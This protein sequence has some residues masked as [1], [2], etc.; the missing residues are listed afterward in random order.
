MIRQPIP[1]SHVHKFENGSRGSSTGWNQQQNFDPL[2]TNTYAHI[3]QE[4]GSVTPITPDFPQHPSSY[5]AG[6][7]GFATGR[8][9]HSPHL[10]P[11]ETLR[12]KTPKGV[13]NEGYDGSG[14]ERAHIAKQVVLPIHHQIPL[15]ASPVPSYNNIQVSPA[16]TGHTWI[17]DSLLRG[18]GACETAWQHGQPVR[19]GRLHFQPFGKQGL[20]QIDSMLNQ[21]SV[22]TAPMH[23]PSGGI[24]NPYAYPPSALPATGPTASNPT[25]PWGP[26]WPDGAYEPYRPASVRD[27]RY[28]GL[29]H[30]PWAGQIG[31]PYP[32]VNGSTR[33]PT[34]N[35]AHS[36]GGRHVPG[37]SGFLDRN[38]SKNGNTQL[39]NQYNSP[40]LFSTPRDSYQTFGSLTYQ[41]AASASKLYSGAPTPAFTASANTQNLLAEFGVGSQNAQQR[42]HVFN[43]AHSAYL[44]LLRTLHIARR[45]NNSQ[46]TSPS[47]RTKIYPKAP[48]QIQVAQPPA[49]P[50]SAISSK[51]FFGAAHSAAS[52]SMRP[53]GA[54]LRHVEQGIAEPSSTQILPAQPQSWQQLHAVQ[55]HKANAVFADTRPRTLRRTAPFCF[56]DGP[57]PVSTEMTATNNASAALEALTSWC[58]KSSWQWIDGILLGGC[59]AY[60]MGDYVTAQDWYQKILTIDPNNVEAMSNLAA[61][62]FATNRPREAELQWRR[63]VEL[64]P[65]YFEAVEHLVGLLCGEQ[66]TRDAIDMIQSVEDALVVP[67]KEAAK[68]MEQKVD[69]SPTTTMTSP[70]ISEASD[71]PVFDYEVDKDRSRD[72]Q[73]SLRQQHA[74]PSTSGYAISNVDAGRLLQL[75]HAKGNMLYAMGNNMAA[76]KAF[77]SAVL[78]GT[79]RGPWE[80]IHGLIRHILH[81]ISQDLARRSGWQPRK[82]TD[83][84]LLSP[85]EALCI[86][87][88]CFGPRGDLPGIT[89]GG[90][91]SPATKAAIAT[92]SNSLL[93]LAKIFQDGMASSSPKSAALQTQCGVKEILALYYLSLAL[94]PSPSTAN[95][96]GIL[97]ASVQQ[98]VPPRAIP[99][100]SGN[101]LMLSGVKPGSGVWL[102]LSYYEY[103]LRLDNRHAHLYT[104]LGSLLKDIGHLQ[105]AVR[106]YEHAVSCDETFDI[107]L[108]NLA[109]AVK[110]QGRINDAIEY[111]KRAVN[112]SP[113]FAEAVCGLANALNSVCGWKGRGGIAEDGGKRDR[114]HVGEDGMLKD[115][116]QPGARSAGWIKR[117]VDL[118]DKQLADGEDWGHH[119]ADDN[120]IRQVVAS[121]AT[122]NS[123]RDL[124]RKAKAENVAQAIRSWSGKKW[125]GAKIIRLTERIMKQLTWQWYQDK[126]VNKTQ[127]QLEAYV[128]PA[129]PA[130]M[131]VPPAPTV[132]PFHT[133]TC[134]M[135]AKQ[136]RQISQRNGLRIST[137]ALKA[138]WLPTLVCEPPAPPAPYLKVGYLSSDFN[139]HPLAHLMQSVFG[140]HDTNKVRAI[141][142]ATTPSDNSIHRQQ[143][144]REA[145]EF[146]DVS[147]WS[148]DK[149]IKKIAG[150]G[151]HIL[152]NLNGY[153]RGAR[154]E[155]FAARPA[156]IQMSFMGF[157]GTLGAEWCDYLL[158]DEIAVP[159]DA[160]RE[161]RR[162]ID[163]EDQIVDETYGGTDE[164]WVYNENIIYCRDTFFCCDHKQSAPDA[165]GKQLEW[166][167]ELVRRWK[168][169]QELFPNL[170]DDAV[171]LGNFNQLYKIEP[172]TFRSWLRILSRC[173]NAI[174]WLLRFPDLGEQYLRQT[175]ELWAG[176][177][178]ASR[179]IFTDVA[180][181][182]MHIARARVC[183]LFLDTPECNAHTTAAD[184]LWS[185]TPLLTLPR[186]KYKMCS[187]MAASILTGALP[188]GREGKRAATELIASSEQDYEEKAIKLISGLK[189]D[190][191]TPVGRLGDMRKLIYEG[192]WS[193]P[194]FDTQRW[195]R[196]LEEAYGI[197]WDRWVRGEGGDITLPPRVEEIKGC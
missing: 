43:W 188:R 96:V 175:A 68:A 19:P 27:P 15:H 103:G 193:A 164:D 191:I 192:R 28:Q 92:T 1:P 144:E 182:H 129:L 112:A 12:R 32:N 75:I 165:V 47:T 86:H 106:M 174:L 74:A 31:A 105:Q 102:A 197:A 44:E 61:T 189:Y 133:F 163:L 63:A 85:E 173:P 120:F 97:L 101:Q 46:G 110:D 58:K 20:P 167:D 190:G 168:M 124:D 154:N 121:M 181:K 13:V 4:P 50:A 146:H 57:S 71:R 155:V 84:I 123:S 73:E 183:D 161:W 141:C 38:I 131:T 179:I 140:L 149:L 119:M 176:A 145:P 172:T 109:N 11:D 76:A 178:V 90:I 157:A 166:S 116:A 51:I 45:R 48:Q 65:S 126:Y 55:E 142:Y 162:N 79:G 177:E 171:I 100:S 139:N 115:A 64:R 83:P 118:V 135:S 94:Q 170:K 30:M 152:V 80:D 134:P 23:L 185:G 66:R 136:V 138:P 7:H 14:H 3:G 93:S 87:R 62:L 158:A 159:R 82:S 98:T 49:Q 187:R 35:Y 95:N 18:P 22:Q 26:F 156:P 169:R 81:V 113:D 40:I 184:T 143:I 108:A 25:G 180:P 37:S 72:L 150:D 91:E 17:P 117:V 39:L 24:G 59:V 29:Q 69:A 160:L 67:K 148:T 125:E 99:T 8:G 122:I 2:N 88:L 9:I 21:I 60:A 147:S 77:E 10:S 104:N 114:W 132:L 137:S 42:D 151:V 6:Q 41:A 36:A 195:V 34:Q 89:S 5:T 196:D 78:L 111:Y 33:R 128:R 70:S 194:L 54:S 127:R 186:Y 56:N 52:Q 130:S 16:H 153:T 107:A 53:H